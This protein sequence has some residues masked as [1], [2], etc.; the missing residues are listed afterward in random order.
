MEIVFRFP[1]VLDE[2]EEEF[3]ERIAALCAAW[4]PE[5]GEG[6]GLPLRGGEIPALL[7]H[8]RTKGSRESA[9][10]EEIKK[11]RRSYRVSELAE[12]V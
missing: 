3:S 4:P 6:G 9:A 12:P 8:S 1:V 2:D 10:P 11:Y 7:E 5:G